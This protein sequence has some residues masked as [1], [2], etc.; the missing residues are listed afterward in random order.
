M[1]ILDKANKKF[2]RGTVGFASSG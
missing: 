1:D 2:G